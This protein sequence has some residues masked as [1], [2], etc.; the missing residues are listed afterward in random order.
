MAE[1]ITSR[2]D[3]ENRMVTQHADGMSIR[4]LS[5]RYEMSRNTVR[6]ILR[7]RGE[8]RTDG[9][10]ALPKSKAPR[11]SQLDAFIPKIL[12]ILTLFPDITAE[13]LFED[14]GREGYKGGRTILKSRLHELRP[15]P[16]KAL[17]IRFETEP[18]IQG[19]VDWSPYKINF[20][21]TGPAENRAALA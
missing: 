14:L 2:E 7:R 8:A 13:R 17:I 4:A 9:H 20:R 5:R 10:D 16:K 12:E 3:L 19:Q 6:C 18:G 11:Q 1:I 15:K 21:R